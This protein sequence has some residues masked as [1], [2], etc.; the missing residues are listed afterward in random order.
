MGTTKDSRI[1]PGA[2]VKLPAYFSAFHGRVIALPI[3]AP[4][5]AMYGIQYVPVM[6]ADPGAEIVLVPYDHL[7][8][9]PVHDCPHC[10]CNYPNSTE[11]I[12]KEK[13]KDKSWQLGPVT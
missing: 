5:I 3:G 13:P 6:L 11:T 9:S 1:K 7:E 2:I 10:K 12:E 4:A 8:F